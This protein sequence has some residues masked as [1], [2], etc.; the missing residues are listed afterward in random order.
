VEVAKHV[1]G[2]GRILIL[3]LAQKEA[4]REGSTVDEP[5]IIRSSRAEDKH[6]QGEQAKGQLNVT[7][8]DFLGEHDELSELGFH[9]PPFLYLD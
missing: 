3:R 5:S 7:A 9:G 4:Q 1:F 2:K 8:I 6:D